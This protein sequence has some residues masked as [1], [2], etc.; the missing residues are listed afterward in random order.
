[1]TRKKRPP[2]PPEE[3]EELAENEEFISRDDIDILVTTIEDEITGEP[4]V[5]VRFANFEDLEEAEDYAA[6]LDELLPLLLFETTRL[7]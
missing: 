6:M 5:W 3:F 7:H 4:T 1:M 2:I